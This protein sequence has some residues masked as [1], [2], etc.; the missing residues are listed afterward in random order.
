MLFLSAVS[1]LHSFFHLG[2]VIHDGCSTKTSLRHVFSSCSV[3]KCCCVTQMWGARET[4]KK[5]VVGSCELLFPSMLCFV[6]AFHMWLLFFIA[7]QDDYFYYY[8]TTTTITATTTNKRNDCLLLIL[9]LFR[10]LLKTPLLDQNGKKKRN[11][12][13]ES[14][15]T[16]QHHAYEFYFIFIGKVSV[17]AVRYVDLAVHIGSPAK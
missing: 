10:F 7:T 12:S 15:L 9:L 4:E 17:S 5:K 1:C 16:V 13:F 14:F 8:Y 6:F 11:A 3:D 2:I